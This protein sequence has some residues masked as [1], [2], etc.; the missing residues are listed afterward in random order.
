M[1][2]PYWLIL[3][4]EPVVGGEVLTGTCVI[5]RLPSAETKDEQTP[6]AARGRERQSRL[7]GDVRVTRTET[8][9]ETIAIGNHNL[10][11]V[12]GLVVLLLL[13]LSGGR[14]ALASTEETHQCLL[15]LTL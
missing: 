12:S 8:T 2:W 1:V 5:Q 7:L 6:A 9:K 14:A 4:V 3:D 10:R 13:L 15:L 11:G